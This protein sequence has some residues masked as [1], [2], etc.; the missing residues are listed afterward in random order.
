M[1]IINDALKKANQPVIADKQSAQAKSAIAPSTLRPTVQNYKVKS[2]FN[3]GPLFVIA[4]VALIAGPV[5]GPILFRAT[6]VQS[7][8]M[9]KTVVVGDVQNSN[10]QAQFSVE[11]APLPSRMESMFAAKPSGSTTGTP[12][13]ALSGVVYSEAGSYCLINGKV[14]RVG[15]TVGGATINKITQSEVSLS[16]GDQQIVLPVTN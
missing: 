6:P 12:K 2:K 10:L 3:W 9:E 14:L 5:A 4:M 1:S 11:E 13:L 8:S 7:E 16:F 15:E